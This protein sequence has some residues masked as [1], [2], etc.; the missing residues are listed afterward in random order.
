MTWSFRVVFAL[1]LALAFAFASRSGQAQPRA[2][3]IAPPSITVFAAASLKESLDT[4]AHDWTARSGQRVVVSYGAT[5]ALARQVEQ[6]APAA[7]F[8]SADAQWMDWLAARKLVDPASRFDLVGNRLVVVAPATSPLRTLEA[9]DPAAWVKALGADGRLA[10]ADI[11]T[12]PA[13]RY[14]RQSLQALRAWPGVR[15]RLAPA[16]NVRAALAFVA[17]GEASLG[18]VYATDAQAEPRVR[19]VARLSDDTHARIVYPTARVATVDAAT[20]AG[21]LGYLRSAQARAVFR[22]AGFTTP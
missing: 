9:R 17:R 5:S 10:I 20:T 14:A 18:V 13:G 2:L 1:A 16:E 8:V 19:I 21:F 11:D 3:G 22:R 12:V 4:V 7:V 15:D 6:G